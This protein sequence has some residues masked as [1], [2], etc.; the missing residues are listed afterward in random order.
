MKVVNPL[1]FALGNDFNNNMY[2]GLTVVH[3]DY[4]KV[5]D[6]RYVLIDNHKLATLF[7]EIVKN[8]VLMEMEK[9]KCLNSIS[10]FLI[11]NDKELK[12]FLKFAKS[13]KILL[14]KQKTRFHLE[15]IK[16]LKDCTI[17]V[18]KAS[19]ISEFKDACVGDLIIIPY[20][21]SED[22]DESSKI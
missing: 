20:K 21:E 18:N 14:I 5:S 2:A 1:L 8:P 16:K 6:T 22:L 7:S 12:E 10:H 13:L 15:E 17:A 19:N 4:Q 11:E 9:A 3:C